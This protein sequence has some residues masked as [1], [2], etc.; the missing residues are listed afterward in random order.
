MNYFIV[1]LTERGDLRTPKDKN[2]GSFTDE[3]LAR[4]HLE[5]AKESWDRA[6]LYCTDGNV[7]YPP[8]EE[9]T[10]D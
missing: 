5:S 9:K 8:V 3:K 2:Y 7:G 10:D 6:Y 1:V 4:K